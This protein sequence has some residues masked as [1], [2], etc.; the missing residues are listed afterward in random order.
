MIGQVKPGRRSGEER[1]APGRKFGRAKGLEATE[2]LSIPG[3]QMRPGLEREA[4]G[5]WARHSMNKSWT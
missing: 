2:S 3:L 5:A 1:R 4:R